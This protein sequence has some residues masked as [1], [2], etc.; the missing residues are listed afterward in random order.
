MHKIYTFDLSFLLW[1][2]LSY[3]VYVL[4]KSQRWLNWHLQNGFA[5]AATNSIVH[6]LGAL[7]WWWNGDCFMHL[8][9]LPAF[10]LYS[11]NEM[12]VA[13]FLL[14]VVCSS[15]IRYLNSSAST[16]LFSL[17]FILFVTLSGL[18]LFLSRSTV[19]TF[20]GL[21]IRG[22]KKNFPAQTKSCNVFRFEWNIR[23]PGM[24]SPLVSPRFKYRQV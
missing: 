4:S 7:I 16:E 18:I 3:F 12:F 10:I 21:W 11:L 23:W 17:H 6:W 22:K 8:F 9:L 24:Q 13:L 19:N 5:R 2:P 14:C 20:F 1:S 15:F